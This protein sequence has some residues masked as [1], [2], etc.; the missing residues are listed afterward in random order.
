MFDGGT[1]FAHIDMPRHW[2]SCSNSL[3]PFHK[4]FWLD[5]KSIR[6]YHKIIPFVR[7]FVVVGKNIFGICQVV[8]LVV[9]Q[10]GLVCDFT[11]GAV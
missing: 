10:S 4:L 2:Y 1:Q 9:I 8:I 5:P 7:V 3:R 6:Q 11:M